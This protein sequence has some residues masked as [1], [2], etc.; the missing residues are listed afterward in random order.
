MNMSLASSL[1]PIE[2]NRQAIK[3]TSLLLSWVPLSLKLWRVR[4][5]SAGVNVS[6]VVPSYFQAGTT[7]ANNHVRFMLKQYVL[8]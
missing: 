6:A 4:Q 3:A 1:R 2:E 8:C 7:S 5:Y